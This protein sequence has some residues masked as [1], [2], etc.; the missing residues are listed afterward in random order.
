M[1]VRGTMLL[2]AG[3]SDGNMY[4][5]DSSGTG[6]VICV[7][8]TIHKGFK[9]NHAHLLL[10][11]R[12]LRKMQGFATIHNGFYFFGFAAIRNG[13]KDLFRIC[14]YKHGFSDGSLMN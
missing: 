1:S 12:V 11:A 6:F 7:F 2:Y 4:C 10:Y 9:E 5:G 3:V 8:A 14:C 13:F